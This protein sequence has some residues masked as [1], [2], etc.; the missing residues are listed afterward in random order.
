MSVRGS[1]PILLAA[2]LPATTSTALT[3]F[4]AYGNTVTLQIATVTGGAGDCTFTM[5]SSPDGG[6]TYYAMYDLDSVASWTIGVN[7][8]GNYELTIPAGLVPANHY[9]LS[10]SCDTAAGTIAIKAISWENPG[11][12]GDINGGVSAIIGTSDTDLV[13]ST[14]VDAMTHYYPGATGQ[15]MEGYADLSLSGKLIDADGTLTLTLECMN[16]EDTAGGDWVQVYFYDDKNDANVNSLTVTNGTL[17]LAASA[18]NCN[19][20]YFRWAVVA[21]GAT[22]TVILKQRRKA[23]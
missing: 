22:N 9:K 2:G 11:G 21:S 20:R 15:T 4:K 5:E 18:N 3:A 19:F 6:A 1:N 23:L 14:N 17:T 7:T 13:D 16:D 8:A 10:Y 12:S